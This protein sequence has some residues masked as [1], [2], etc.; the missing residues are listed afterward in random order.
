MPPSPQQVVTPPASSQDRPSKIA[1]ACPSLLERHTPCASS[2][3]WRRHG[4]RYHLRA[5]QRRKQ[6]VPGRQACGHR[7]SH[8]RVLGAVHG[9]G[10]PHRPHPAP[11]ADPAGHCAATL[12]N[13]W[14]SRCWGRGVRV[15]GAHSPTPA[16][17]TNPAT[18]V[19][20]NLS[21]SHRGSDAGAS[22]Y[23][24]PDGNHHLLIS[25]TGPIP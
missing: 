12:R 4:G 9:R 20:T 13:L 16:A 18:R 10:H 14:W 6:A 3:G 17:D 25:D 24:L 11:G 7:V 21:S 5:T 22:G 23:P 1:H 8:D 19:M 15:A 2:P